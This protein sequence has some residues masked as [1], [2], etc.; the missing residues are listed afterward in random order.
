[1]SQL[2]GLLEFAP[3]PVLVADESGEVIRASDDATAVLGVDGDALVGRS[4]A[5]LL[6]GEWPQSDADALETVL[7]TAG[8]E[9]LDRA[10]LVTVE[11]ADGDGRALALSLSAGEIDGEH[12]IVASLS[13]A[14]GLGSQD[15]S[16]E[17]RY[18]RLLASSP[19]PIFIHDAD[20]T[21]VYANEAAATLHDVAEAGGLQ[22]TNL[23][24]YIH[25]AEREASLAVMTRV[26]EERETVEG[27][28]RRI[29]T[30]DDETRH[31][32]LSAVPTTYR[33]DPAGQVVLSD[34]T[35]IKERERELERQ[36][37]RLDRFASLVSH[38]LRNP[39]TVL[40]SSLE[41]TEADDEHVE[42]AQRAVDRMEQLVDGLLTLARQGQPIEET[43]AV[44]L[45][46]VAW[47]AWR[48]VETAEATLEVDAAGTVEADESRLQTLLEN[49][50]RNAVEHGGE[51][52]T[53]TVASTPEGFAVADDG[54]GV[55]PADREA[56]FENGYTTAEQGTGL[57]LSI[58]AEIA[59]AHGWEVSLTEGEQGG[60]RFAFAG[61]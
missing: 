49:L 34:V 2:E 47:A 28:E 13:G 59:E 15:P 24:D 60:A 10:E 8:G 58:V 37:E 5:E 16:S 46:D 11:P 7:Q 50:F 21:I 12:R 55:P 27:I 18:R 48:Q 45:A 42:R 20:G 38:D 44:D 40:K 35:G 32:V 41:L 1:M 23:L 30:A 26:V 25:P 9:D 31:V 43:T 17:E 6:D 52:V 39:L 36:N 56:V 53:V 19:A 51:D 54:A 3:D 22:G 33:G 61:V 4:L 57:G 29:V 14:A